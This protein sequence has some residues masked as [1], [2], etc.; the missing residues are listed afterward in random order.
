MSALPP[1]AD[2]DFAVFSPFAALLYEY[3]SPGMQRAIDHDN[4]VDA[5]SELSCRMTTTVATRRLIC[6]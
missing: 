5:P 2:M 3:T 6:G 4:A 1:K